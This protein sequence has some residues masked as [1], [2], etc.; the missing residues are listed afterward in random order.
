MGNLPEKL[1]SVPLNKLAIPGEYMLILCDGIL[2][3]VSQ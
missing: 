2:H 3:R 1:H